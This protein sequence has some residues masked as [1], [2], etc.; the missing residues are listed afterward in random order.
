MSKTGFFYTL[1]MFPHRMVT[2]RKLEE[3]DWPEVWKLMEPVFRA[4]ETYWRVKSVYGR[5]MLVYAG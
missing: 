3:P 5:F 2:I 4:G 1:V